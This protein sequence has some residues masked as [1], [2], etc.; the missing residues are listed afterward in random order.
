MSAAEPLVIEAAING[1]TPQRRQPRTPRSPAEVAADALACLGAGAAI[2]H[3]HTEEEVFGH[4]TGRHSSEPYLQA[5][6]TVLAERPDAVLYPTM[7]GGGRGRRIEDRYAHITELYAAGLLGMAVADPGSVNLTGRRANGTVATPDAPYENSP[8]DVAWMFNW[9]RDHDVAAHVSIFEPGFLRLVLGH[10]EAGSLP[11]HIKLQFYFSGPT[12]YFGLPAT[13]WSLDT[14]LRLLGDAPLPWMVGVPGGDVVD[15]GLAALAIERGGH[16]RVGL[17]DY[18]GP[19]QPTNAE[20]VA[21]V[22]TLADKLGR[23]IATCDQ[24]RQVL[25]LNVRQAG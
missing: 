5:W 22:V 1:T 8:A 3:N 21:E 6:R 10:L 23:P 19:R 16:V 7:A 17:E 12:S 20:L 18:G 11:D 14:Y 15:S 9:C 13:D 2:V 25:G 4:P 24:T